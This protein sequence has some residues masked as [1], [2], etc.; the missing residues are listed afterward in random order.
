MTDRNI[1]AAIAAIE[2]ARTLH[3]SGMSAQHA[4]ENV[5]VRF[6]LSQNECNLVAEMVSRLPYAEPVPE[7]TRDMRGCVRPVQHYALC[8]DDSCRGCVGL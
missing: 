3:T 7:S 5:Q 8:T 2:A 4:A 6:D 1:I